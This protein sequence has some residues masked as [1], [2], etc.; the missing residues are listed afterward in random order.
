MRHL[1]SVILA[2][3]IFNLI[4]TSCGE[5]Y[6]NFEDVKPE[7][8][9]FVPGVREYV[10][11]AEVKSNNEESLEE[12]MEYSTDGQRW[13]EVHLN[14]EEWELLAHLIFAEAGSDWCSDNMMYYVG[15]VVLNRIESEYFPN[16]M[17][18]VIYQPGQYSCVDNGMIDYEYNQRA[19]NVAEDLLTSGSC[20]PK[21]VVFQAQFEQGDGTYVVVQNMYFCYKGDFK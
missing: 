4:S 3:A 14:E 13:K 21:N 11:E 16:T 15:S 5:L 20:L 8:E 12:E 6:G 17:R 19:Y 2:L 9:I 10:G 18:E 1:L 7:V